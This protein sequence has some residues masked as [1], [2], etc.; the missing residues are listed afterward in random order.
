VPRSSFPGGW[1]QLQPVLRKHVVD[2]KTNRM[3][4]LEASAN[5][6]KVHRLKE[7]V[8]SIA[9]AEDAKLWKVSSHYTLVFLGF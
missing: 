5:T 6:R 8:D 9:P 1:Q 4:R 3:A 2:L 7:F